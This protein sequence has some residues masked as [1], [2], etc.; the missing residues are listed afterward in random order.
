MKTLTAA[1]YAL[2]VDKQRKRFSDP[3]QP[4][5][6]LVFQAIWRIADDVV[7][8]RHIHLEEVLPRLDMAV[9]DVKSAIGEYLHKGAV[10]CIKRAPYV[11]SQVKWA[12][13]R[14]KVYQCRGEVS[15]GSIPAEKVSL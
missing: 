9:D 4:F 13:F 7:A 12:K 1:E 10:L 15:P 8:L 6:H 5:Q 3:V 2:E 14:H 11:S